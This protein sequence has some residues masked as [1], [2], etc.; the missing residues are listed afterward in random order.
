MSFYQDFNPL[1]AT[2]N[3][4][5]NLH[6]YSEVRMASQK[7]VSLSG[8]YAIKIPISA[9]YQHSSVVCIMIRVFMMQ[10]R[11]GART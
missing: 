8:F 3:G 9:E 4:S 2:S 7:E 1:T 5:S 10:L 11:M 6:N